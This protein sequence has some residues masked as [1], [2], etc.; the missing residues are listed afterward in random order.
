MKSMAAPTGGVAARPRDCAGQLALVCEELLDRLE[1]VE[2]AVMG[3][4]EV[5]AAR[6]A[7][8]AHPVNEALR[9]REEHPAANPDPHARG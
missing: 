1:A 2:V 6:D 9:L 3:P 8:P 5:Q 4:P 7:I